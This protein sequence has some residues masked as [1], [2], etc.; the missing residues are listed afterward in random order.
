MI[1]AVCI[2]S[3]LKVDEHVD[4]G[5]LVIFIQVYLRMIPYITRK[6]TY[7]E[8]MVLIIFTVLFFT[9]SI[10]PLFPPGHSTRFSRDF[11][12]HNLLLLAAA[13]FAIQHEGRG[14][15]YALFAFPIFA[16]AQGGTTDE[17]FFI[18]QSVICCF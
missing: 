15:Q 10:L 16:F 9:V 12:F 13:F 4:W 18:T 7:I 5:Y 11:A 17:L 6:I 14:V 8:G 2:L 1:V 3:L